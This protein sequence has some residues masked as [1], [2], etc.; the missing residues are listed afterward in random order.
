MKPSRPRL[1]IPA[2]R[3]PSPR[4]HIT[5]AFPATEAFSDFQGSPQ[6]PR[7]HT[8][9]PAAPWTRRLPASPCAGQVRPSPATSATIRPRGSA[10]GTFSDRGK[11]CQGR[12]Q[13]LLTRMWRSTCSMSVSPRQTVSA[14]KKTE[15][16]AGGWIWL[17]GAIAV[18]HDIQGPCLGK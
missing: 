7:P 9:R 4:A 11:C 15:R 13:P 5:H 10:A 8:G 1:R 2:Q 6:P 18:L 16:G 12:G 14:V 3:H 17:L